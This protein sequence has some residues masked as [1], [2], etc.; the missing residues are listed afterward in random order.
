MRGE[1]AISASNPKFHAL[2][3]MMGASQGLN[4]PFIFQYM[5][6]RK[7]MDIDHILD[8]QP[9]EVSP[10]QTPQSQFTYHPRSL[11]SPETMMERKL[12]DAI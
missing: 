6:F 12:N 8:W 10:T 3:R 4:T 1:G 9:P 7:T 2:F 5:E 11:W